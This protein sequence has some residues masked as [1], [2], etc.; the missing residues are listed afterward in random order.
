M[1]VHLVIVLLAFSLASA[2]AVP[3]GWHTTHDARGFSM[4]YPKGWTADSTFADLNYP[5]N[6]GV[7][8]KIEGLGVSPTIDLQPGTTLQS[9]QVTVAVEVLPSYAKDCVAE[10]FLAQQPPDHSGGVD[11]DRP[12]YAHA[13]SG[14]PGGWYSTE[15]FVYRISTKPCLAVHYFVGFKTPG[16]ANSVG[17]KQFDRAKLL[18]LLDTIRAKVAVDKR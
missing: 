2:Y 9:Q 10:N 16:G 8:L 14:D 13:E 6:D 12:D 4:S 18:T 5:N 1:R 15:D 7:R 11:V 3:A 17:E